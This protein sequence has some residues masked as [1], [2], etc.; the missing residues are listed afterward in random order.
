M[1]FHR[2]GPVPYELY[3][4]GLDRRVISHILGYIEKAKDDD[5]EKHLK[6]SHIKTF[7]EIVK[8]GSPET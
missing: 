5:S 7:H 4:N 2:Q 1:P 3:L 6:E 8:D